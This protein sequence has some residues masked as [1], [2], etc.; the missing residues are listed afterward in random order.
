MNIFS[1]ESM[2]QWREETKLFS[3]TDIR[4]RQQADVQY[5]AGTRLGA[6]LIH[7]IFPYS[8]INKNAGYCHDK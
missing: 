6:H 1:N 7:T 5:L 2:E 4:R 3:K 8:N